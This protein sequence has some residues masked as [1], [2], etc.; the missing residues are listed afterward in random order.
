MRRKV[1]KHEANKKR[2]ILREEKDIMDIWKEYFQELLNVK[3]E[4]QTGDG[5]EEG[6]QEHK[7][8]TRDE[9]N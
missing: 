9:Q 4:K 3:C 8:E 6:I 5:E 1:R 7:E 2:D